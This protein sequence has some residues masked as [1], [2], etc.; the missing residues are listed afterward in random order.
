MTASVSQSLIFS[1]MK[2]RSSS[3]FRRY[4]SRYGHT[5]ISADWNMSS[6]WSWAG[7]LRF[8]YHDGTALNRFFRDAS[9]GFL[10]GIAA[11]HVFKQEQVLRVQLGFPV[12]QGIHGIAAA[13]KRPLTRLV[14]VHENLAHIVAEGDVAV[15]VGID[16]LGQR[17]L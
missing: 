14:V 2:F 13:G 9:L 3:A 16:L 10:F 4:M 1:S 8:Q 5:A 7:L 17:A 12:G 6:R 11:L 15:V